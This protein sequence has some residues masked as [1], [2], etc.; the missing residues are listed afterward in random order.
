M[1]K[2]C[3]TRSWICLLGQVCLLLLMASAKASGVVRDCGVA[4]VQ[5]VVMEKETTIK[6]LS[7][8]LIYG[9][10]C[11]V[12]GN[13]MCK[14]KAAGG[15]SWLVNR[16]LLCS[17]TPGEGAKLE[18]LE[19]DDYVRLCG[20]IRSPG[21]PPMTKVIGPLKLDIWCDG[22]VELEIDT[23][24]VCY[25]PDKS[26]AASFDRIHHTLCDKPPERCPVTTIALSLKAAGG[27]IVYLFKFESRPWGRGAFSFAVGVGPSLVEERDVGEAGMRE[28]QLDLYIIDISYALDLTSKKR[29]TPFLYTGLGYSWTSGIDDFSRVRSSTAR[30]FAKDS[31]TLSL[32]LGARFQLTERSF[33]KLSGGGRWYE[34][35]R[36]DELDGEVSL[37]IGFQF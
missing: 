28:E 6:I 32:G 26:D 3:A 27:D 23:Y 25:D 16:Q 12:V 21:E 18:M 2:L 8:P 36:A 30:R 24:V 13:L 35:R 31:F 11:N 29:I 14:I 33:L 9:N 37:G 34:A 1:K 20:A 15:A 22:N 17:T 10:A 19:N 5:G 7:E 4:S